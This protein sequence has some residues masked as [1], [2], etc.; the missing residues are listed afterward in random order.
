ML[1]FNSC[2]SDDPE[3]WVCG[4][5]GLQLIHQGD[6]VDC[7]RE[8]CPLPPAAAVP[9]IGGSLSARRIADLAEA[10]ALREPKEPPDAD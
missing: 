10:L 2:N 3:T 7:E 4:L 6:K 1:R 8:E 9:R 5:C